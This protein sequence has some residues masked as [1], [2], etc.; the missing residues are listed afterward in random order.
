MKTIRRL[1]AL[2]CAVACS[3]L[4]FSPAVSAIPDTRLIV[5]KF[6]G[7]SPQLVDRYVDRIDPKT[8]RSVLPWIRHLFYERGVRF[9]NFYTRGESLSTPSWAIIDTGR[10]SVVKGNYEVDRHTGEP[11]DHLNIFYFYAEATRRR[12]MY[13]PAVEGLDAAGIPL[14]SDAFAAEDRE[15]GIQLVRRGTKFIDLL[16]VGL[17]PVKGPLLAR[18]GD[19]I[20]GVDFERAYATVTQEALIT[21]I[22]DPKIHYIDFY[23]AIVDH[24]IHDDNDDETILDALRYVDRIIGKANAAL[25]ESGTAD[26][27]ILAVVS[28]HGMTCD[29][30]GRFSHGMNL[31][32]AL[33]TPELGGHNVLSRYPPHSEFSLDNSPLKPWPNIEHVTTPRAP[34]RITP[35]ANQATCVI[36]ADGNERAHIALRQP[37]LNRLQMLRRALSDRSLDPTA[38]AAVARA[39]ER[40][41]ERNRA[42]WTREAVEIQEE[43]AAMTRVRKSAEA[44]LAAVERT[45][46][47]N[48]RDAKDESAANPGPPNTSPRSMVNSRFQT[49]DDLQRMRELHPIIWRLGERIR[50][51]EAYL[52]SLNVRR[53]LTSADALAR[54]DEITVFGLRDMG[55]P[56][57][58]KQVRRYPVA[59]RGVVLDAAGELDEARSFATVD[60]GEALTAIRVRNV[61]YKDFTSQ[62]IAYVAA[63][64]PPS[65]AIAPLVQGGR[66][67]EADASGV[68]R[69]YLIVGSPADQLLV[70]EKPSTVGDRAYA[71]FP[72]A[73]KDPNAN[74]ATV[75]L[76]GAA[77]RAGLPTGLFEDPEF[78]IPTEAR[79]AWLSSF[80]TDREWL[81]ATHKTA[82]GLAI[83]GLAE[84]LSTDYRAAFARH[85]ELL[86]S[87]DAKV[88]SR[89]DLRMRDAVYPDLLV[90]A[91]P[92]WN[93]NS[94]DTNPGG[95]HG[96]FGRQAMQSVFWLVGGAQT[97]LAPGPL[98]IADP[99]DGLD[100]VPTLMEAAGVAP[101]GN[102]VLPPT[103]EFANLPGRAA[104]EALR[105]PVK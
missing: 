73:D 66:L 21:A 80:H 83:V 58:W 38:R 53:S 6:D 99:Y 49:T 71:V 64:V 10:H 69:A 35:I 26:R 86:Q 15:T 5:L 97:R 63:T 96:G 34:A 4:F 59:L 19:L 104:R 67:T 72:V 91:S 39:A 98:V 61:A 9:G 23:D 1:S 18:F 22:R 54:A 12:R 36:D 41:L 81:Q 103:R 30:N 92:S 50:F 7:L 13:P 32:E 47:A 27:T 65:E 68:D 60:Y 20:V 8:G 45:L 2:L 24:R 29:L 102:G 105:A 33:T 31:V 16:N 14:F 100:V 94:Q 87:Q 3:G 90:Y 37:D 82:Q 43:L 17:E 56:I 42:A 85:A 48:R 78:A 88:L 57:D 25:V 77:W 55:A 52:T 93:F 76:Q 11:A 95:N 44:E 75:A 46:K 74:T 79:A 89:F 101:F 28:D 40:I 70:L 84:T 62:P 51:Y